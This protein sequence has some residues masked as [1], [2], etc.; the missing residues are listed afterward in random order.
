MLTGDAT[1]ASAVSHGCVP[2]GPERKITKAKGATIYEIDDKPALDVLNEYADVDEQV[3]SQRAITYLSLA[4]R[5][6]SDMGA[7]TANT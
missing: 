3:D 5:A 1:L 7:A 2:L 4:F 6:T